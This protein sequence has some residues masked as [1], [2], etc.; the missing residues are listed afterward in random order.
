MQPGRCLN[1]DRTWPPPATACQ[2]RADRLSSRWPDFAIT[3]G[4]PHACAQ[5]ISWKSAMP[6]SVPCGRPSSIGFSML[7]DADERRPQCPIPRRDPAP[8]APP[9]SCP[10]S[11]DPRQLARCRARSLSLRRRS[12][13]QAFAA[14]AGLARRFQPRPWRRSGGLRRGGVGPGRGRRRAGRPARAHPRPRRAP[15]CASGGGAAAL[16]CRKGSGRGAGGDLDRQR[17]HHQGAW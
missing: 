16:P 1:H 8:P 3:E 9:R 14:Q 13:G 2:A 17:G 10:A 12:E 4:S 7:L 6:V 5:A 11:P 15:V